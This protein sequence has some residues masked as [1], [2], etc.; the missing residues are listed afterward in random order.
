MISLYNNIGGSQKTIS[1]AYANIS[2]A[3]KQTYPRFYIW[4]KYQIK[5]KY[6]VI[7]ENRNGNYFSVGGITLTP[8]Y[9]ITPMTY[10]GGLA[11]KIND[12]GRI[13]IP[14]YTISGTIRTGDRISYNVEI[15][16]TNAGSSYTPAYL[17]FKAEDF[18]FQY[19]FRLWSNNIYYMESTTDINY[20]YI[21]V[22]LKA[23][24]SASCPDGEVYYYSI[25]IGKTGTEAGAYIEQVKSTS[26]SAYPS[27]GASGNY[28]YTYVGIQP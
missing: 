24:Y 11:Y 7:E 27:N 4:N 5:D 17:L 28:W 1:S 14:N 10:Y 9:S 3:L 19:L 15:E 6:S 2:G 21:S 12:S 25:V 20:N 8:N 16:D 18:G 23:S 26:S 22:N 13:S